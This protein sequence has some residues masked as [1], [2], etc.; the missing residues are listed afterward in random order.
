VTVHAGKNVEKQGHSSIAG[1]V[2]HLY[3]HSGNQSVKLEIVL[4]ENPAIPCL[5]YPKDASPF[6]KDTCFTIFTAE[7][8]N[9][10]DVPQLKNT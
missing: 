10:P 6:Q 7:V 4:P 3:N 1:R 8:G 5:V 9:N 2:A